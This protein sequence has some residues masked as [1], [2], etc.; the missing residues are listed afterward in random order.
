VFRGRH[1]HSV[2]AK[3]RTSLPA[4][5]REKL[6]ATGESCVVVARSIDGCLV[7]YPLQ[8]W[9]QFEQSIAAMDPFDK[10]VALL[11]RITIG[12]AEECDVDKLGRLVLPLHLRKAAG[13]DGELLWIGNIDHIEVWEPKAFEVYDQNLTEE[14]SDV[15]RGQ[16]SRARGHG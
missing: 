4:R 10:A 8:A 7:A 1:Q 13:I 11:R 16:L 2:D 12:S 14:Q 6:G 3:G 15:L 9:V 5:F